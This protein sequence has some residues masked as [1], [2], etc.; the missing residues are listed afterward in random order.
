METDKSIQ[1]KIDKAFDALERIEKVNANPFFKDKTMQ[2]LFS[3][4]EERR[5]GWSWFTPTWQLAVLICLIALNVFVYRNLKSD[6]YDTKV[7]VFAS[8]YGLSESNDN[9]LFN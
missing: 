9:S 7:D 8:S 5:L 4:K 1:N 6:A 2:L 3:G